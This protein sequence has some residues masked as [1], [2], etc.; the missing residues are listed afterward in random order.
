VSLE[1]I[2]LR[3]WQ[4]AGD[5]NSQS[6]KADNSFPGRFLVQPDTRYFLR[7]KKASLTLRTHTEK[8]R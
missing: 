4:R 6:A 8:G 5:S 1:G 3:R 7:S 2:A